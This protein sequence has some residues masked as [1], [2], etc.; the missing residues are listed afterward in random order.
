MR[1]EERL[2]SRTRV[3]VDR[4][5]TNDDL[6]DGNCPPPP[7][8]APVRPESHMSLGPVCMTQSTWLTMKLKLKSKLFTTCTV[9]AGLHQK[10]YAPVAVSGPSQLCHTGTYKSGLDR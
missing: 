1:R 3:F 10:P 9:C 2:L 8:P 5:G 7:L 6:S 4:V